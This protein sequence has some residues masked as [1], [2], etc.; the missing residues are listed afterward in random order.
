MKSVVL[1]G[2]SGYI[3]QFAIRCLLDKNYIVHA[4]TSKPFDFETTRNL[5]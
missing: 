4:V 2:A 1:T 3:G 5:Y